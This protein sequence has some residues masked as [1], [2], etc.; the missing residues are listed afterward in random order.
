MITFGYKF[1]G[2]A[3]R[4]Y[5]VLPHPLYPLTPVLYTGADL[6]DALRFVPSTRRS[7]P[8]SYLPCLS[9]VTDHVAHPF[10][11]LHRTS[12][13]C[14]VLGGRSNTAHSCVRHLSK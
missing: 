7:E 1:R 4:A 3:P 6:R 12:S 2:V 10:V 8:R 13:A 5:D 9:T 14:S 11:E